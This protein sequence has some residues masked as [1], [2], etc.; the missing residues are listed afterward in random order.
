MRQTRSL[1][2]REKST[3]KEI[4]RLFLLPKEID[5]HK[6]VCCQASGLRE[7]EVNL[8]IGIIYVLRKARRRQGVFLH[9]ASLGA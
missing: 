6:V 2:H 7:G 8:F 5:S 1:G 9:E 4:L 3:R